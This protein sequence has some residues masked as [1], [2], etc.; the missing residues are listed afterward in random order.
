MIA[1]VVTFLLILVALA[2][3]H[4]LIDEKGYVLIAFD[5]TTIEGTIVSFSILALLAVDG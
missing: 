1:K 2:A 4:L 5:N 3:G